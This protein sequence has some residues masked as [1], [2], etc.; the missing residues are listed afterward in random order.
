[1]YFYAKLFIRIPYLNTPTGN[2]LTGYL[3]LNVSVYIEVEKLFSLNYL[4]SS[5][6]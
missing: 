1:M 3:F 5:D 4:K 6:N 2:R